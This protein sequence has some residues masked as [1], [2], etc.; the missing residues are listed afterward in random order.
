LVLICEEYKSKNE[1][2]RKVS[3]EHAKMCNIQI[4]TPDEF[5]DFFKKAGFSETKMFED[6]EHSWITV[7]GKK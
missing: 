2:L 7:I 3:E 5:R 1:A 6:Q 4:H